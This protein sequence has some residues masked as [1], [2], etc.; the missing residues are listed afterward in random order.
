MTPHGRPQR[1]LRAAVGPVR[2]LASLRG[3]RDALARHRPVFRKA[4]AVEALEPE[5]VIILPDGTEDLWSQEYMEI[6]ELA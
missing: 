1:V 2:S 6:V 5:R 4:G 3:A